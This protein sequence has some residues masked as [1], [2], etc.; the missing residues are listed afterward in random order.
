MKAA[1]VRVLPDDLAG[2]IDAECV[3]AGGAG[4]EGVVE[5][6]IF[7]DRHGLGSFMDRH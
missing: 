3:G 1:A 7:I 4:G 6:R 5:G 2:I